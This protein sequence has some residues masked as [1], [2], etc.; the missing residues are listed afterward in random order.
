MSHELAPR[1]DPSSIEGPLYRRWSDNGYFH[2]EA[3]DVLEGGRDPYVIVIPPPNVTA[4]LHMGHGL[5]NTIQ[6]VLIRF[7]RM[8]GRAAE[9][10]PGTDHAGIA[11][12]NVVERR[13]ADEGLTRDDLG[14]EAFV[15]RVWSFVDETGSTILEQ[16]KAIGCSCDWDRTAFT[17]DPNLSEA[18]RE[19]FVR[20]Y[21]NDR[22]YRGEYI[23]N[24]CPRC[25]TALSNE[26]AEGSESEGRLWHLRYPLPESAWGAAETAR[27]AGAAALGRFDD[28]GWYLTVSTTRP[29]TMLG[30]QAV[31]VHP[32]DE[33]YRALVGADVEL[34]LTGRTIP[35]VAD[36]FVD[37]EFGTGMVKVTPAHD[38]NDFE[39]ARR[40]EL[41]LLNI[42]TDSAVV[43]EHAPEA[44][45]GMDRFEARKAV[46]AALD[47]AGLLAGEDAHTHSVPRCYRC[48]TVVEPR[49]SLQWFVRMKP[50]AEPALKASQNGTIT[51][52]PPR[53]KKVYEHWMENI[54]DWCI[55]RQLWWGHRIPVWY[56]DACGDDGVHVLRNE[57]DGCPTCGGPVHQDPDVLDTWFSSWLWPL[58]PFGWPERTDDLKAFYPGH[59]LVTAPEIL[60]FWVA[61][62]IM[63]GYEFEGEP[64]FREVFLHGTVRDAQGRKMSKSLGNGIDPMEV[65]ERF[66]ADAMR[67]TLVSQCAIGTDIHLD[68]EDIEGAFATGR[69]F[70]NK[71]W[72]V[73]RFTLMSVGEDP[74]QPLARVVDDLEA[75]DRWI[76]SRLAATVARV[77]DDMERFRLHEVADTLYH[78]FW[79][80]LADWYLELVK[81]RLRGD[82]GEASREAARTTLVTVLDRVL[83]LLHPLVPFVSTALWERL[84]WPEGEARPDDLIVAPWPDAPDAWTD[85][86]AEAELGE[87][88]EFLTAV[89]SLRKEY[90]VGEGEGVTV[91][92]APGASRIRGALEG[93]AGPLERMAR[94]TEVVW[95]GAPDG[96]IGAHAV[97]RSGAD[98]F[99]PLEGVVDLD[100]ER[101]RLRAEIDRLSGQLAG[102]EKKLANENFVTRA[103]SEVVEKER[104]K[105]RSQQEQIASLQEKLDL[106]EGRS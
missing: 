1:F 99:L 23:I 47:D 61:R 93:Q 53:W 102:T 26:E 22:V 88:Q 97:L 98:V 12:Q 10:L 101:D 100:R 103:P 91:H 96:A 106:L 57:P 37:P 39:I 20:L 6:D 68:H 30:D 48:D 92:V 77:T 95:G 90:G 76:L 19:V 69:N 104:D 66:G 89:R 9:W 25:L 64:P 78:F 56:C 79:G 15:E 44:F 43:N 24:W 32:S 70:A 80:D 49:L 74:V 41:P 73:G 72:N 82:G 83:R 62:M 33:R 17:L 18:V 75:V 21:E 7:R 67:F 42:L 52:T 81:N 58:S 85:T 84:P 65:V 13:I 14:R 38:P 2:V 51:F 3:A 16:L 60:F 40:A 35:V 4:V 45:R 34:P 46:L 87:L 27:A 28:G 8:Q 5:N 63:A 29:E 36:A 105:A 31:A 50:L 55:S 71:V 54:R 59:T 86:D 11:T 94:V